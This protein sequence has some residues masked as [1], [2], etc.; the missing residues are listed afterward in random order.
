MMMRRHGRCRRPKAFQS[1]CTL[2]VFCPRWPR[3][4]KKDL[5]CDSVGNF[6]LCE[7]RAAF[8][9]SHSPCGNDVHVPPRWCFATPTLFLFKQ[10]STT[11]S[12]LSLLHFAIYSYMLER[13]FACRRVDLV[14]VVGVRFSFKVKYIKPEISIPSRLTALAA[15]FTSAVASVIH[16]Y[17]FDLIE[18]FKSMRTS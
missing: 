8:S 11:L 3:H 10:S 1:N 6:S 17:K 5:V 13:I 2:N 15:R 9:P 16:V 12:S 4:T 14:K 7:L 18:L